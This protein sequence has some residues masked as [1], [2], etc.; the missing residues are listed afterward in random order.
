MNRH[1]TLPEPNSSRVLAARPLTPSSH[2]KLQKT[3]K[4]C[5]T[6]SIEH[7]QS[8]FIENKR[9]QTNSGAIANAMNPKAVPFTKPTLFCTQLALRAHER[10][11][12]R[13]KQGSRRNRSESVDVQKRFSRADGQRVLPHRSH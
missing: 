7:A 10:R 9:C 4:T 12:Q 5:R 3:F 2:R 6:P 11:S 13:S 8:V 1:G